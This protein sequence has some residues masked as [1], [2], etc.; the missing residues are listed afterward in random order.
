MDVEIKDMPDLRV[1]AV[2]HVGPYNQIPQAFG[3]LGQIA[4]PAG[5]FSQPGAAMVAIYHDDPESVPQDQLRSDAGI[6]VPENAALPR[7]L[8][9][10]HLAAGRYAR[11][12]HIGP[13]EQLGDTWARFMGEW[14]PSSG[15]RV[16]NGAS[17]ELYRNDPR[18][19][20]KEDLRTDLYVPLAA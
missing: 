18:T 15:H 9:E 6:V 1:V 2:R 13:Y 17:Y 11:T 8:E 10:H 5:L 4:G 16:G 20:P 14:L 19:T 12:V 7:G 3:R